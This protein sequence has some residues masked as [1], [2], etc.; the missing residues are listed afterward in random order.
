MKVETDSTFRLKSK[1]AD[2][3]DGCGTNL[4]YLSHALNCNNQGL[5]AACHNEAR[6]F[7]CDLSYLA[8]LHDDQPGL[9]ADWKV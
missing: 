7:H 6:D 9:R 1:L 2:T 5:F 4:I 8:V 3:Y